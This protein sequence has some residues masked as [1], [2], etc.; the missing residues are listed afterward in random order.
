M[1]LLQKS[2]VAQSCLQDCET[3]D[4]CNSLFLL[5]YSEF[6]DSSLFGQFLR[7]KDIA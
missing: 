5:N 2:T 4:F 1:R 7:E 3:V 6:P